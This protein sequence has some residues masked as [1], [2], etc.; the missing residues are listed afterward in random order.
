MASGSDNF[1]SAFLWKKS[2]NMNA[3]TINFARRLNCW[4]KIGKKF[5]VT[6]DETENKYNYIRN[7][8]AAI[9]HSIWRENIK[10]GSRTCPVHSTSQAIGGIKWKQWI[11]RIACTLFWMIGAIGAIGAIIWKPGL[12][13]MEDRASAETMDIPNLPHS[14]YHNFPP[15]L[16][17]FSTYN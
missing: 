11:A 2:K 16:F 15:L 4:K 6:P 13:K 10:L 17:T 3:N 12:T 5:Q 1:N 14:Q 9:F 8:F 7:S